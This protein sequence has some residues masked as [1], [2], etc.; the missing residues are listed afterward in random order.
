M[1]WLSRTLSVVIVMVAPGLVGMWL[2]KR[3]GTA[4]FGP[5]GFVLGMGLS[6]LV[7]VVLAQKLMPPA[8]GQPLPPEPEDTN[9]A[10]QGDGQ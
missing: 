4:I 10:E 1:Q 3:F 9:E 7:L 6:T 5:V 8:R 2:D